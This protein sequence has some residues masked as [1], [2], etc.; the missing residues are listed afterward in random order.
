M[1]EEDKE[2]C[3]AAT[4]KIC[5]DLARWHDNTI[6]SV[7]GRPLHDL[8]ILADPEHSKLSCGAF[9]DRYVCLGMDCSTL[10]FYHCDLNPR[11]IIWDAAAKS[12][13]IIDWEAAGFVSKEWIRT[14][15]GKPGSMMLEHDDAEVDQLEWARRFDES[16]EVEGFAFVNM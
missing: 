15:V 7:D 14:V 12:V 2:F 9:R 5:K 10:V 13:G 11:N 3:V 4:T 16:L 6:G 1:S 8:L